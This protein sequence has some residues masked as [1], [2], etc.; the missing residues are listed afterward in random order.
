MFAVG[1]ISDNYFDTNSIDIKVYN[2]TIENTKNYQDYNNNQIEME[3]CNISH[4][5]GIS[6]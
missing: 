6:D 2:Y 3:Y 4:W 5:E 1:V